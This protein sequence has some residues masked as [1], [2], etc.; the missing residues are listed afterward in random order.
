[1]KI[2]AIVLR[3]NYYRNVKGQ[4]FLVCKICKV[5]VCSYFVVLGAQ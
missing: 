4:G 5:F 2:V 3:L 1:V